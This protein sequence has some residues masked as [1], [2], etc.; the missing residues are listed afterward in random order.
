MDD[1]DGAA[2]E[3]WQ[4]HDQGDDPGRSN[5]RDSYK[6]NY[7]CMEGCGFTGSSLAALEHWRT[8]NHRVRDKRWPPAWGAA[9]FSEWQRRR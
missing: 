9:K 7:V 3:S 1:K 8:T 4:R 5:G 6:G 2:I